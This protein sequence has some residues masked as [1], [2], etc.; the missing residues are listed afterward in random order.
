[1]INLKSFVEAIHQAIISASDTLMDKNEGLL[2]KYFEETNEE[3]VSKGSGSVT[4]NTLVP[5]NVTLAYPMLTAEGDVKTT[6]IQVPLIT[7]VP[8]GMSQIE[9]AT[10]T[11]DFELTLVDEE[12]QLSFPSK[13]NR[14]FFS[15]NSDEIPKTNGKLEIVISPQESSEGLKMIVEAYEAALKRQ[16]S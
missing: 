5:K 11:A 13:K 6:E 8:L 14:G 3:V 1:M 16:I 12:L 15:R 10:I 4:K 7:L 2:D 9:K